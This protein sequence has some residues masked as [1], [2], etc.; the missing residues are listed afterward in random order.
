MMQGSNVDTNDRTERAPRICVL[1][2]LSAGRK[3]AAGEHDDLMEMFRAKGAPADKRELTKG[4]DVGDV[5]REVLQEDYDIIVA[6]GGDGTIAGAAAAMKG[7]KPAFGVIPFGTFNYFARS[8][9]IPEEPERAVD[10]IVNGA[11]KSLRLATLN[12]VV[13]LNNA[14]F[15]VY[16]NMLAEREATYSR[17]GRSRIAAYW[18]V[19]TTLTRLPKPLALSIKTPD[20]RLNVRTPV[21]FVFNNAFQLREMGLEGVACIEE[22]KFAVLVSRGRG[23]W[24]LIKNGFA[25]VL[26]QATRGDD[27]SLICAEEVEITASRK[28]LRVARDGERQRMKGPYRFRLHHD[29]IRVMAPREVLDQ[30]R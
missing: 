16:P 28:A 30:V 20:A 6:A 3:R 12:D 11:P 23:R 5:V 1:L 7:A 14:N 13:F 19:L 18:A 26:G 22:G 29:A 8:L 17:W 27:F 15:G 9:N 21:A 2:N 24:G 25:L 10:A 4:D